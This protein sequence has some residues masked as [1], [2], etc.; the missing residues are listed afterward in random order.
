MNGIPFIHKK[1]PNITFLTSESCISKI[2]DKITKELHTVTNMYK[3]RG[4]NINVYHGDKKFNKNDLR[5]H[6]R[7]VSLNIY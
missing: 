6:I 5:D 1:S 4:I 2:S 3:S 7:L